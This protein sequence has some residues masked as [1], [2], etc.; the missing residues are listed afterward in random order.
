MLMM[1]ALSEDKYSLQLKLF[2]IYYPSDI[3]KLQPYEAIDDL[4]Y[5][6]DLLYVA[7]KHVVFST[8]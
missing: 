1:N 4:N 8:T 5:N 2:N 6:W 3:L 7:H